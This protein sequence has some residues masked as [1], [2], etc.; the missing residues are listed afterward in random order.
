MR[1]KIRKFYDRHLTPGGRRV[2][3]RREL[4]YH[5]GHSPT[6][7]RVCRGLREQRIAGTRSLPAPGPAAADAR[8]PKEIVRSAP[9]EGRARVPARR[10]R[11][12]HCGHSL[13]LDRV[14]RGLREQRIAGTRSLPVLGPAAGGPL[15]KGPLSR[16]F[17]SSKNLLLARRVCVID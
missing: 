5:C 4:V 14:C 10:E 7:D 12:Y 15:T 9:D 8:Q 2:L 1:V 17:P 13:T 16:S 11:F 6:L 3:A